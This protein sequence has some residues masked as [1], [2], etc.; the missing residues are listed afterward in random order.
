[1]GS[2]RSS[3][4]RMLQN[5]SVELLWSQWTLKLLG[6]SFLSVGCDP[7]HLW[8][9][10]MSLLFLGLTLAE[11]K[12]NKLNQ[13]L[14]ST[15]RMALSDFPSWMQLRVHWDF[16]GRWWPPRRIPCRGRR[17][18]GWH[19]LDLP[20]SRSLRV[21]RRQQWLLICPLQFHGRH[22]SFRQLFGLYLRCLPEREAR[23]CTP[24]RSSSV[25]HTMSHS[26]LDWQWNTGL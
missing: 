14:S 12:L 9:M 6:P 8:A 21:W 15:R 10:M 18:R 26:Y 3:P 22:L 19:G 24:G 1:M 5:V 11:A 20:A 13:T 16:T 25:V 2:W 17:Y 23:L 7:S 4:L